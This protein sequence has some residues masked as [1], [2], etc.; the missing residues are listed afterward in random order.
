MFFFSKINVSGTFLHTL[1]DIGAIFVCKN[2]NFGQFVFFSNTLL[3]RKEMEFK[4][5]IV[6]FK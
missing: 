2:F 5:Y 6:N 1:L 3:I 4:F